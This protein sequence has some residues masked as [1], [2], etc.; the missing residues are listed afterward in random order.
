MMKKDILNF[1]VNICLE[2]HGEGVDKRYVGLL[3]QMSSRFSK[4]NF[5]AQLKLNLFPLCKKGALGA[6]VILRNQTC[7]LEGVRAAVPNSKIVFTAPRHPC[8]QLCIG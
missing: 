7:I 3:V 4:Q 2:F 8:W 5:S 6:R 1:K